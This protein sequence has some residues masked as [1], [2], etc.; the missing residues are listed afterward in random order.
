MEHAGF[1]QLVRPAIH[2]N[3]GDSLALTDLQLTVGDVSQSVTVSTTVAS[4]PLD[5]GQ[6]SSTISG[7]RPGAVIDRGTR[8]DGVGEHSAGICYPQP[9]FDQCGARLYAGTDR[10]ADAVCVEWRRRWQASL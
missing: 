3:A 10:S 7:Q 4:L 9:V 2:L 6:L 1:K 5:S 8:R